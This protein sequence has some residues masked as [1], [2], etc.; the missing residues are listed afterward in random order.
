MSN[1][2]PTW[3]SR[4]HIW[5][6]ETDIW[7]RPL[8]RA[9]MRPVGNQ[10]DPEVET[11]TSTDWPDDEPTRGHDLD[12]DGFTKASSDWPDPDPDPDP[13]KAYIYETVTF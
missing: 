1:L 9:Y 6:E 3:Y 5:S 7:V 4:L 8:L 2:Q 11:R 12:R 13:P 10:D